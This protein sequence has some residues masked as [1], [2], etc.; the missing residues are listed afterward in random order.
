MANVPFYMYVRAMRRT[1]ST[2]RRA[3]TIQ[4]LV[5]PESTPIVP[6]GLLDLLRKS[7][8]IASSHGAPRSVGVQLV[9]AA[10]KR[11]VRV[12]GQL[13][14]RCHHCLRD[15]P[16]A[17]FI[18]VSPFD[19]EVLDRLSREP[20]TVHF[21]RHAYRRGAVLA[22]VCTGAFG[23]AE[24]GL[25]DGRPAATHWAFQELFRA[26]FPRVDLRPQEI[27]VDAGRLLSTGGATSF[28]NF[29]LYLVE[30]LYG[31]EVARSC[32]RMFLIDENKAPQG[33]Y[34]IF[35]GQKQHGDVDILK[36]QQLIERSVGALHS[37][38]DIAARMS[39]TR[40]TF[41][42]RFKA[43]TGSTPRDYLQ[44]ARVE[45]AKRRLERSRERVA[46]IATSVGYE[47]L[48]AFRRV[49]LRHVGLTP[50]DYRRRCQ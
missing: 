42:R 37:V 28:L 31:Q 49:F 1:T 6:I 13:P 18:V 2:P 22:S 38:E 34:A 5:F 11:S 41:I 33:A 43:A 7:A 17:D 3:T 46:D 25:L 29:A 50:T 45:A 26:R 44:R 48:T 40:R 47:D 39:M 24:T 12:A 10:G 36:A 14:V 27:L 8:Q 9:A 32:A 15:A 16:A 35:A 30:R 19:P 23:L 21:L 20:A 4:I